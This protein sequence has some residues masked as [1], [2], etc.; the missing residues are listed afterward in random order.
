VVRHAPSSGQGTG[1]RRTP[2]VRLA[3]PGRAGLGRLA[4]VSP[5][6]EGAVS[7][8]STNELPDGS[9]LAVD[10]TLRFRTEPELRDSLETAGF[11][12]EAIYGG[13]SREPV[14]DGDGELI[15]VATRRTA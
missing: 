10:S 8:T 2:R 15:V 12:I 11:A 7:F 9:V 14:G 3:R 6:D 1:P 4:G 5:I 13:W